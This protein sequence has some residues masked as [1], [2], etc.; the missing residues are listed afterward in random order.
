MV[1]GPLKGCG[2]G[3]KGGSDGKEK[4]SLLSK[5]FRRETLALVA[6]IALS[7]CLIISVATPWYTIEGYGLRPPQDTM[8]AIFWWTGMEGLYT[9]AL[10]GERS[11]TLSWHDMVSRMPRDVYFSAVSMGMLAFVANNL[12][13]VAIIFGLGCH[14]T[15]K[16]LNKITC[17][18]FKWVVVMLALFT[19]ALCVLSWAIFMLINNALQSSDLCAGALPYF[20]INYNS[21]KNSTVVPGNCGGGYWCVAFGGSAKMGLTRWAWGPSIGWVT[22]VISTAPAFLILC[23]A[24]TVDQHRFD[25]ERIGRSRSSKSKKSK[26]SKGTRMSKYEVVSDEEEERRPIRAS[27]SA[28]SASAHRDRDR[29][30]ERDRDR[31]HSREPSRDRDREGSKSRSAKSSKS[32]K[33]GGKVNRP[34]TEG[35]RRVSLDSDSGRRTSRTRRNK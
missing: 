14:S 25:Y 18:M 23:I 29:D 2:G 28:S 24:L 32:S 15:S 34:D 5:M 3:G 20:P 12:M 11:V 10:H 35:F 16:L 7:V 17:G 31:D 22:A 4:S 30:R 1:C 8:V 19:L 26:A 13:L 21:T 27:S 9:P 33:I 6:S